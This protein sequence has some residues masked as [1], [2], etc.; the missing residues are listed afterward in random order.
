MHRSACRT[1]AA[2]LDDVPSRNHHVKRTCE[3]VIAMRVFFGV[4]HCSTLRPVYHIDYRAQVV[5]W[6][7]VKFSKLREK[8][9]R[10]LYVGW[11]KLRDEHLDKHDSC[12]ACGG[13]TNLQVHHVRP[14]LV[15]GALSPRNLITLCMGFDE[16]HLRIGHGGDWNCYNPHVKLH[17]KA[18]RRGMKP[19]KE[20]WEAAA[21]GRVGRL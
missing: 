8:G 16:C 20:I 6:I 19:A 12:A 17:A 5:H 9:K 4:F 13:W 18:F 14:P 15:T 11:D 3:G 7:R 21:L 10:K 1:L 2:L